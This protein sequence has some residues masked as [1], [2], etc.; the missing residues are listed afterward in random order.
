LD[1]SKSKEIVANN[2][3]TVTFSNLSNSIFGRKN[4][5]S[6][7]KIVRILSKLAVFQ[8]S[9]KKFAG[10]LSHIFGTLKDMFWAVFGE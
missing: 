4:G 3:L 10:V 9:V 5:A 2:F 8:I 1:P 6:F 7:A